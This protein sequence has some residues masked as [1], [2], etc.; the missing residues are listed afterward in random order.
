[1]RVRR[2]EPLGVRHLGDFATAFVYYARHVL[3]AWERGVPEGLCIANHVHGGAPRLA[4]V[5]DFVVQ[6]LRRRF[7]G[8]AR[9]AKNVVAGGVVAHGGSSARRNLAHFINAPSTNLYSAAMEA[10]ASTE[11]NYNVTMREEDRAFYAKIYEYIEAN[12][13]D[14]LLELAREFRDKLA[15]ETAPQDAQQGTFEHDRKLITKRLV[16][17][18]LAYDKAPPPYT[19]TDLGWL[20]D[21]TSFLKY[22][23]KLAPESLGAKFEGRDTGVGSMGS[24]LGQYHYCWIQ[25]FYALCLYKLDAAS[26]QMTNEDIVQFV[27]DHINFDTVPKQTYSNAS[28]RWK[29]NTPNGFWKALSQD[30][31]G[32]PVGILLQKEEFLEHLVN[33]TAEDF[34]RAHLAIFDHGGD[35]GGVPHPGNLEVDSDASE[36]DEHGGGEGAQ[37]E[38][39]NLES[40]SDASE[41]NDYNSGGDDDGSGGEQ[42]EEGGAESDGTGKPELTNERKLYLLGV[43]CEDYIAR[44]NAIKDDDKDQTDQ[45]SI[46]RLTNDLDGLL[47]MMKEDDVD[48]D[49]IEAEVSR[50]APKV[51]ELLEQIKQKREL[52][53]KQ[54][55]AVAEAKLHSLEEM[56]STADFERIEYLKINEAIGLYQT[57]LKTQRGFEEAQAAYDRAK[58]AVNTKLDKVLGD[59]QQLKQLQRLLL[60]QQAQP[61]GQQQASDDDLA[62]G[63]EASE[64]RTEPTLPPPPAPLPRPAPVP[65]DDYG[66]H[67]FI[68]NIGSELYIALPGLPTIFID[69]GREYGNVFA[70]DADMPADVQPVSETTA[71]NFLRTIHRDLS[72]AGPKHLVRNPTTGFD[73]IDMAASDEKRLF[74]DGRIVF[75]SPRMIGRFLS[76]NPDYD[77]IGGLKSTGLDLLAD[78]FRAFRDRGG[79]RYLGPRPP[80]GDLQNF[81]KLWKWFWRRHYTIEVIRFE[82]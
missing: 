60:E 33:L 39:S 80:Y 31:N 52:R 67:L 17:E 26:N 41:T 6:P 53:L 2:P 25:A 8:A 50:L 42:G 44:L 55:I 9:A 27:Y 64:P 72:K 1:V 15:A 73:V 75:C 3:G 77:Y 46:D 4:R 12:Y 16:N 34:P 23:G 66:Y 59:I 11:A 49:H 14:E 43:L 22:L 69:P 47:E 76:S 45:E 37:D 62:G 79:T 61:D 68:R 30:D 74:L 38:P 40:D 13:T 48:P 10:H 29:K 19:Y 63:G 21:N 82:P 54:Q 28:G 70:L 18:W 20:G 78:V 24:K 81:Q 51:K 5:A 71:L 65:V 7:G 58:E 57:F 35:A 36:T 56:R 32:E